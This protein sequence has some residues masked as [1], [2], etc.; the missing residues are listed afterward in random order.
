MWK[1]KYVMTAVT[2]LALQKETVERCHKARACCWLS[3][4]GMSLGH[5]ELRPSSWP[6]AHQSSGLL[7][8]RRRCHR[9]WVRLRRARSS[10][11][12][13]RV[14]AQ[15]EMPSRRGLVAPQ[16]T[17]LEKLIRRSNSQRKSAVSPAVIF[18]VHAHATGLNNHNHNPQLILCASHS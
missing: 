14:T 4:D 2:S 1:S 12:A 10:L 5:S 6:S 17:F 13:W 18:V 11:A 9:R 7:S 15:N 3:T 8:G 16:N